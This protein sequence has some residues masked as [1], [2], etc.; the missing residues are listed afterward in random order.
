MPDVDR[1]PKPSDT[2]RAVAE[3]YGL[4]LDALLA[5]NRHRFSGGRLDAATTLK[6][7]ALMLRDRENEA[8]VCQM[9]PEVLRARRDQ[10]AKKVAMEQAATAA[11][12]E[13]K[14]AA[15]KLAAK[16]AKSLAKPAA[17][18]KP[19]KSMA[20]PATAAKAAKLIAKPA[21]A[22]KPA[23]SMAKLAG[24]SSAAED[25]IRPHELVVGVRCLDDDCSM[26]KRLSKEQRHG[27]PVCSNRRL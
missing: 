22:A 26:T 13:A 15:K 9:A 24:P 7:R 10:A 4:P 18:A 6:G 25:A 8:E 11:K 20:K 19:T 1:K 16:P 5:I 14:A 12:A 3:R 21:A 17:A 23:K 27:G 2:P